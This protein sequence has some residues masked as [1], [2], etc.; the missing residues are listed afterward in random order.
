MASAAKDDTAE[1]RLV[2][3]VE[4][5][6]SCGSLRKK[7]ECLPARMEAMAAKL[8]SVVMVGI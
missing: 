8:M 6:G 2:T 7:L 5:Q 4:M 1:T 3:F